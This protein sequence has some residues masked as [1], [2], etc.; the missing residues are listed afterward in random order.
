MGNVTSNIEILHGKEYCRAA[1]PKRSK[2]QYQDIERCQQSINQWRVS[3]NIPSLKFERLGDNEKHNHCSIRASL[4]LRV[5]LAVEFE[6]NRP[7]RA[8]VM[9][10]GHHDRM[11]DHAQRV[12]ERSRSPTAE[13]RRMDAVPVPRPSQADPSA[14]PRGGQ[15]SGSSRYRQDSDRPAP[16]GRPRAALP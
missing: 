8:A 5:F 9:N 12:R 3:P 16:C 13:L 15:D 14:S 11:Y 7:K 10:I 6:S 4:E 2:L 1:N